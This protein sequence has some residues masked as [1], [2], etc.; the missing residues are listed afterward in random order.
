MWNTEIM[1][2]HLKIQVV[3]LLSQNQWHV[4]NR[5]LRTA[6]SFPEAM[7]NSVCPWGL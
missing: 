3:F 1:K 2:C 4:Q 7:C 5:V 6:A